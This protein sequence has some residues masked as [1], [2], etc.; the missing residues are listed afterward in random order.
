MSGSDKC[1]EGRWSL[2][3]AAGLPIALAAAL[4]VALLSAPVVAEEEVMPEVVNPHNFV[5]KEYC[6]ICHTKR[7]PELNK[8]PVTTCTKCHPANVGNHPVARHP[9]GKKV[10][11]YTPNKLP[12]TEDGLIVCYTCHDPHNTSQFKNMLRVDYFGLCVS[13]HVGY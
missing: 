5:V 6:S 3:L 13:C 1:R 9:M 12:L 7:P 4:A 8:D 10:K 11:I 2:E